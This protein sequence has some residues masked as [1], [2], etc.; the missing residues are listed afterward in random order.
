MTDALPGDI[1]TTYA[2]QQL[3]PANEASFIAQSTKVSAVIRRGF[4]CW[5]M[6]FLGRRKP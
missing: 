4:D 6:S 2:A 5:F 3:E 1:A